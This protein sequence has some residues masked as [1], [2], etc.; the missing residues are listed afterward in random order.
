MLPLKGLR[1]YPPDGGRIGPGLNGT[2]VASR[3]TARSQ[4]A[5]GRGAGCPLAYAVIEGLRLC[6]GRYTEEARQQLAAAP[7]GM[8]RVAVISELLVA[9]HQAPVK[10]LV[11]RVELDSGFVQVRRILPTARVFALTRRI[12]DGAQQM[13]AQL[14]ARLQHPGLFGLMLEKM[15][16]IEASETPDPFGIIRVRNMRAL[17]LLLELPHVDPPLIS[18]QAEFTALHAYRVACTEQ[19]AQPI[20]CAFE[21]VVRG[22]ALRVRPQRI[23]QHA[24]AHFGCTKRNQG[25]QQL[26]RF[27]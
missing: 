14:L 22:I 21:C 19:L 27:A 18:A 10:T 8:Q 4:R 16:L 24:C 25:L 2:T 9:E 12:A 11:E 23:D 15:P 1:P 6:V 5:S 26:L 7:V 13:I 17:Q 20:K 3:L